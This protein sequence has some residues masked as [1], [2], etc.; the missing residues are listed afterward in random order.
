MSRLLLFSLCAFATSP[1]RIAGQTAEPSHLTGY[2]TTHSPDGSC[3]DANNI[4]YTNQH[5]CLN[6]ADPLD[7]VFASEDEKCLNEPGEHIDTHCQSKPESEQGCES[8]IFY[9]VKADGTIQ[10]K[11]CKWDAVYHCSD[12]GLGFYPVTKYEWQD[13]TLTTTTTSKGLNAPQRDSGGED[14]L[15]VI[16]GASIGGLAFVVLLGYFVYTRRPVVGEDEMPL[17]D[18]YTFT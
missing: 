6:L 17:R 4:P 7:C 11:T 2:T 15:G 1:G 9:R 3:T 12:G 14:N 10:Q 8:E 5:D 16:L 13:T 18:E